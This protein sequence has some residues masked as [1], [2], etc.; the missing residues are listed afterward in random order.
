MDTIIG[1]GQIICH[2]TDSFDTRDSGTHGRSRS[3]NGLLERTNM[4]LDIEVQALRRR[5]FW[6]GM[7]EILSA[8]YIPKIGITNGILVK[9]TSLENCY[10]ST[11]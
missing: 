4:E 7:Q 6:K 3:K 5:R 2:V 1:F 10:L 11:F 9:N 8:S